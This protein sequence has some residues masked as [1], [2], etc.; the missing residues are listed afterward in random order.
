MLTGTLPPVSNK[1][2]WIEEYEL[3]DDETGDPLDISGA[4]EITV[5]VRDAKSRSVL[6][7]ATL[8][9]GSIAHAETGVFRWTFA[10]ESMRSLCPKTYEIGMTMLLNDVTTQLLIGHVPVVDGVVS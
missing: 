4:D 7:T 2:D 1:A 5:S 8:S 6:L 10:A 9:G 3:Y